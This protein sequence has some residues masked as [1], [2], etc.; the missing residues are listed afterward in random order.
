MI[1]NSVYTSTK[2]LAAMNSKSKHLLIVP[3]YHSSGCGGG[4][5]RMICTG[6]QLIIPS[7][8]FDSKRALHAI[9]V[10]EITSMV[11][12]PTMYIGNVNP[13]KFHHL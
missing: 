4:T 8:T 13:Y 3:L 10:E 7:P 2:Q 12:V 6:G 11:G 1:N 9:E 5:M